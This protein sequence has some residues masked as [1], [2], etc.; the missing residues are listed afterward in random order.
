MIPKLKTSLRD[1]RGN[2]TPG[3]QLLDNSILLAVACH[4]SEG[5]EAGHWVSYHF[6]N[7]A[8]TWHLNDDSNELKMLTG[9]P[10]ECNGN[11]ETVDLLCY[12]NPTFI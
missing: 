8:Q 7:D 10:L 5:G 2:N 9:N 11:D 12:F 3:D 1:E 4:R 6:A